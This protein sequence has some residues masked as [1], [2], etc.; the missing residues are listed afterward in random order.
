MLYRVYS[1]QLEALVDY[2]AALYREPLSAPLAAET[3]IVQSNGM[4]RWLSMQLASRLTIAANYAYEFPSAFLW[5]CLRTVMTDVPEQTP[6]D[7][8]VLQWRLFEQL[9]K[10]AQHQ[11][12]LFHS[13]QYYLNA[14]G[15]ADE[16]E[17]ALRCYQLAR[18]IAD[19]YDQ[20]LIYRLD[21]LNKWQDGKQSKHPAEL[22]QAELWRR[23]QLPNYHHRGTF[24]KRFEQRLRSIKPAGLPQRT[25]LLG[26]SAL[27]PQQLDLFYALSEYMDVHMLILNPCREYWGDIRPARDIARFEERQQESAEDAYLEV[28]NPLLASLGKQG[29]DFI[30]LLQNYP[31]DELEVYVEQDSNKLLTYVQTDILNLQQRGQQKAGGQKGWSEPKLAISDQDQS[32]QLHACH[33]PLREI[34]VLHDQLL[35]L[36]AADKSLSPADIIVMTPDIEHYSPLIEA[37]FATV[38][39]QQYIPFSIA[40]RSLTREQPLVEAALLLLALPSQRFTTAQVMALLEFPALRRRFNLTQADFSLIQTWLRNTAI[41]WGID[42]QQRAELGLP[43]STEHTWQAGLDRLLCGYALPGEQLWQGILPYDDV[44]GSSALILG[45]FIAYVQALFNL[46]SEAK[47]A[48]T[49]SDWQTW[50]GK[51]LDR[52][53]LAQESEEA[54]LQEVRAGIEVLAQSAHLAESAALIS[55]SVLRYALSDVLNEQTRPAGFFSGGVTFCTLV[56]MRSI[57]FRVVCLIGMNQDAY[58]RRQQVADFD[59]IAQRYRKGDRSRRQDDR[60]L[61]LE[62]LLSARQTFYLSYI[63]NNIRD[64]SE[65]APSVLVSELI[66]SLAKGFYLMEQ[67]EQDIYK[68]LLTRHPLQAFS[69]VYFDQSDPHL[70]SYSA[71]LA[72]LSRRSLSQRQAPQL[73]AHLKLPAPETHWQALELE[74]LLDFFSNPARFLLR[75]R[76]GISLDRSKEELEIAEPFTLSGLSNYMLSERILDYQQ[77]ELSEQDALQRLRGAGLL[78]HGQPGTSLM[79]QN[80]QMIK[81]FYAR[82]RKTLPKEYLP[83][84]ELDSAIGNIRLRGWL[85]QVAEPGRFDYRP[86]SVKGKDIF[87]LWLQH[88]LL[89]QQKPAQHSVWLGLDQTITLAPVNQPEFYLQ[90][91]AELYWLGLQQPLPFFINSA[92]IYTK[93]LRQQSRSSPQY[94]ASSAWQGGEYHSGEGSDPYYR[95]VYGSSDPLDE[96]FYR[97]AEQLWHPV[98]DHIKIQD[99]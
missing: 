63:G 27:P 3:V 90:P 85:N 22:W 21:W 5:R 87:R 26:I 28:G 47:T 40:D 62:A 14:A 88:L 12:K 92:Y 15:A 59:L 78:P 84:I 20:Y 45:R 16:E 73:F 17:A 8:S 57:P 68:H 70:F 65:Q 56:P 6:Y 61:F 99:Q 74:Q 41:R 76:L 42:Q 46:V 19:I 34:E 82:L 32:I 98:F 95:L 71:E 33:S 94:A 24:F 36:F 96:E 9:P 38:P 7:K 25:A 60:Y 30:D 79:Q 67:P 37:V 58:P 11:S 13:V 31:A 54:Q 93:I 43:D 50:L 51:L 49:I 23:L 39:A 91:L 69:Q 44:E 86:S 97:L 75:Q 52:F 10:I 18:R 89:C 48:R 4:A 2:L 83:A 55:L 29:R 64:N 80:W 77:Q 72:D 81:L 53:F 66:D 1:N 35:A